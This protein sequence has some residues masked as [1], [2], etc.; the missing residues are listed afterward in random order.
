MK[1]LKIIIAILFPF[2]LL[3]LPFL[4]ADKFKI[5]I[6]SYFFFPFALTWSC[7]IILALFISLNILYPI[8]FKD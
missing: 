7:F 4:I 1:I 8:I 5:D 3:W 6:G 2:S